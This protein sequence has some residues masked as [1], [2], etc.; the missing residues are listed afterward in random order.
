ME[1]AATPFG[2]LDEPWAEGVTPGVPPALLAFYEDEVSEEPRALVWAQWPQTVNLLLEHDETDCV[3]AIDGCKGKGCSFKKG[4]A[5]SPGPPTKRCF[6]D[7]C[8]RKGRLQHRQDVNVEWVYLLVFDIDRVTQ[9]EIEGVCERL[10]G[11]ESLLYSTHSHEHAGPDD[12]CVRIVLPLSRALAASEFKLAH[13]AVRTKYKLEWYRP[14]AVVLTGQDQN[15]TNKSRLYYMPT[16]PRGKARWAAYSPGVVVDVD[17]L[18]RLS[19]PVVMP[20]R[21]SVPTNGLPPAPVPPLPDAPVDM[22]ALRRALK[23]HKP[24]RDKNEGKLSGKELLRR[25]IAGEPLVK[26]EETGLRNEAVHRLGSIFGYAL[27]EVTPDEAALEL[28]RPSINALPVYSND[29]ALDALSVRFETFLAAI[30]R[31][32]LAHAEQQAELEAVRQAERDLRVKLTKRF[33]LKGRDA[34]ARSSTATPDA[35][36]APSSSAT[37]SGTA[38]GEPDVDLTDW[39]AALL[40]T[41]K[42]EIWHVGVNA[43]TILECSDEWRGKIRYNSFTKS[44]EFADDVPPHNM[45]DPEEAITAVQYWLQDKPHRLSLGRQDIMTAIRHVAKKYSYNPVQEYLNTLKWD[46][47][48]R[49]DTWLETYCGASLVEEDLS[50]VDK[51]RDIA[52]HVRRIGRRWMMSAVARALDP[53][54]KA[55]NVLILEG[56]QGIKK[57]TVFSVLAS[58]KWFTDSPVAIGQKDAMQVVGTKWIIEMAEL[59]GLNG[60]ETEQQKQF[61]SSRVDTFRPPF[62]M[63]PIDFPRH[64]VCAGTTNKQQY[65]SDE[66]G[67]R[68][69]W[70][71]WCERIAI[72][73]LKRD[74][75]QLWAEAVHFYKAGA[76]CAVCRRGAES[77]REERCPEHR[78]WND[79]REDADLE[80]A[81][82]SRLRADYADAISSWFIENAIDNRPPAVTINTVCMVILSLPADRITAQTPAVTRALKVLQFKQTRP[83]VD[84]RRASVWETPKELLTAKRRPRVQGPLKLGTSTQEPQ[85]RA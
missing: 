41:S 44:P 19:P 46:G 50:A 30:R 12:V 23:S 1:S 13:Q 25:A 71:V 26:F 62:G 54:C 63:V 48:S 17:E 81:N 8:A 49:L 18:L 5:F 37:F 72:A 80:V 77:N 6:C 70:A 31:A 7:K 59:S 74:R 32:R 16:V 10:D 24:K 34:A 52:V 36:S 53:G 21:V 56:P 35:V 83:R 22:E 3:D 2:V 78:W 33:K 69:F 85:A 38:L 9:A 39:Q 68:R 29:T 61:F 65:L 58:Q 64:S 73:D 47:V 57:S 84:G 20:P 66:T 11:V 15:A 14:D 45:G 79:P 43:E 28:V 42:G 76:D 60:S 27:P 51:Q 4:F 82:T 67:N 40:L 55:D 75:D